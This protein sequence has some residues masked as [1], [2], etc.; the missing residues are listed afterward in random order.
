[1]AKS[2]ERLIYRETY[3]KGAFKLNK[4]ALP[5][6]KHL[7]QAGEAFVASEC[8]VLATGVV[9]RDGVQIAYHEFRVYLE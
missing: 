7:D 2:K 5:V 8:Y 6:L 4:D 1:M 9:E 3:K